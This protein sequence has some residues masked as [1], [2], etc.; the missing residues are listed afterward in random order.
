MNAKI[1]KTSIAL[2]NMVESRVPVED[3]AGR[4][5]GLICVMTDLPA[6]TVRG[7]G[8]AFTESTGVN[9]NSLSDADKE[10]FVKAY[11]SK[12]DGIGY[13]VGRITLASA[14]FGIE[15]YV[16]IEEGDKALTSFQIEREK[17]NVLP[18][19]K[20]ALLQNPETFLYI[21]PWSAPGFM[22][23]NGIRNRG[24]K[25]LPEYRD[26][27]AQY[28]VRFI[29]KLGEEG[30]Q[31]SAAT[32]Q[33]EPNAR[34]TWESMQY[35]VEEE[36]QFIR[37]HLGP[38]LAG[39]GIPVMCWD[40]NKEKLYARAGYMFD[41]EKTN[42]YLMGAACHWYSGDHFEQIAALKRKY[43][44]KEV[45]VSELCVE[46]LSEDEQVSAE[47]YAHEIIG[48]F[49][50]GLSAFTDWNMLL[51]KNGGPYHDRNDGGCGAPVRLDAEGNLY[52]TRIFYYIGHFSKYMQKGARILPTSRFTD[53]L[54]ALS[55]VNPDG[56]VG[57]VVLNRT[58]R[59]YNIRVCH[60]T[61]CAPVKIEAHSILTCVY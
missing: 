20:D 46:T 5:G 12:E 47:R 30:I 45:I 17:K 51:D 34:Q 58:D 19:V 13:S 61:E 56:T 54:E 6:Q 35:T 48:D 55:F 59:D 40:H 4:E 21:S 8:G 28:F 32:A 7:F 60:G 29:E 31:I 14:D 16:N 3:L 33:N 57:T 9:Y 15:D 2:G 26:A 18:L 52:F 11:F 50:A 36:N 44:D 41:D 10:R 37:D 22:K 49:N 38:K 43:P 39:L 24:G 23:D 42:G 1:I 53:K 27:W 25:L